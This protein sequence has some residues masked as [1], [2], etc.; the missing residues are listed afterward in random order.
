MNAQPITEKLHARSDRKLKTYCN[1]RFGDL[2]KLCGEHNA[3]PRPA[4]EEFPELGSM[5]NQIGGKDE[6]PWHGAV[7][8]LANTTLFAMLRDKWRDRQVAEFVAQVEA[9]QCLEMEDEL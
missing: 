3:G 6:F 4:L 2:F 5:L 7:W 8:G 9:I 1:E